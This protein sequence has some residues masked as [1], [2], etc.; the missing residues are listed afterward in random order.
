M[1]HCHLLEVAPIEFL[2]EGEAAE[3]QT[4]RYGE[5]HDCNRCVAAECRRASFAEQF[6]L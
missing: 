6:D 4:R 3:I 2:R 1:P 5:L